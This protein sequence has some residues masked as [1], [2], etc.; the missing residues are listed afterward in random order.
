MI[1]IT[2]LIQADV[3]VVTNKKI[4]ILNVCCFFIK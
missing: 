1:V 3:L 2:A 4:D